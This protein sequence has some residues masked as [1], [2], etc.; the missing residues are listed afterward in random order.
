M[1]IRVLNSMHI[2]IFSDYSITGSGTFSRRTISQST[3][4]KA[5]M[6]DLNLYS[7]QYLKKE[8]NLFIV[9]KIMWI[10]ATFK[11]KCNVFPPS[12]WKVLQTFKYMS[13]NT[14]QFINNGSINKCIKVNLHIPIDRF[15]MNNKILLV[16]LFNC[17][18]QVWATK[19]TLIVYILAKLLSLCHVR[20]SANTCIK[21]HQLFESLLYFLRSVSCAWLFVVDIHFPL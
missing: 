13:C 18:S 4:C 7:F 19:T 20:E 1:Y 21:M 9:Y 2:E 12:P 15:M 6:S 10:K 14:H 8:L 11:K 5:W 16:R 3:S 17:V